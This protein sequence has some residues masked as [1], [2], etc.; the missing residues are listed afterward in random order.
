MRL[1]RRGLSRIINASTWFSNV[2]LKFKPAGLNANSFSDFRDW[3]P[4]TKS[5]SS[6]KK[7]IENKIRYIINLFKI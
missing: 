7:A 1:L 4:I 3:Y 2:G 5:G 6:E